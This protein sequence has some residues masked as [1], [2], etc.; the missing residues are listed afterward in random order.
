MKLGWAILNNP[1]KLWVQVVT[2]KYLK[3]TDTGLQLRRKTGGSALWRGIRAVWHDLR[4]A[5]Q[6]NVR[7]GKGTLFWSSRWLDSDIILAIHAIVDLSDVD[8]QLTVAEARGMEPPRDSLGED[9]I[10]WGPDPRGKFTLKT[11]YEILASKDHHMDQDIWR[12]IWRWNG[13]N[14]VKHFLWLVA[15][16][17]ILTNA[18]RQRRHLVDVA[19]CQRCRGGFED[20]LHVVRDCQLAREVWALFIPPELSSHFFSDTLQVWLKTGLTHKDFEVTFGITIWILWKERNEAIFEGKPATCDQLRLRVLHWIAGVRET[21]RADSQVT[22]KDVT[23]RM[24]THIGWKAG[25]SDCIT[26]NTDGSVIQP[27][28][29]A[30]AGGVLR[31]SLGRPVSSFAA[32]LGRCSIMRAELRAAE[33]GLMIAWDM[34]FKKVHL[35]LDSLAAVTAILGDLEEDSR[36]G[37]T[38]ESI[39]EIRNRDW[40]VT[41]SHTFREG[42]RVADLRAHH[43]HSLDFGFHVDCPHPHE[44]V[45]AIWHD[46]VG[47]CFPRTIPIYE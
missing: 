38:L 7:N 24:D 19:T 26:I 35:Q 6:Q 29:R 39:F 9:G 46:H 17:R 15:H 8:M 32:N 36:H 31:T 23:R 22:S 18:E 40:D 47:T 2:S 44:V 21:M 37:R 33:I 25:P 3:D 30:A 5:C 34:G 12:T 20:T 4:G 41:I 45:S 28:S 42:N 43:G 10:I 27:H 16:N 13:P 14:R 1:D 11:A